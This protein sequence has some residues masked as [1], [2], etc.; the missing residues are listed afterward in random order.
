MQEDSVKK[1]KNNNMG[2]LCK[3]DE[4]SI[5]LFQQHLDT[6]TYN[7]KDIDSLVKHALV[8]RWQAHV[9]QTSILTLLTLAQIWSLDIRSTFGLLPLSSF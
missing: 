1:V 4:H 3:T 9:S 7:M 8:D 2:T 5:L 6:R